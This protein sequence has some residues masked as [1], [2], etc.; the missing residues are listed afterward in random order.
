MTSIGEKERATQKRAIGLFVG[1]GYTY[2]GNWEERDGNRNIEESMLRSFL[3]KQGCREDL[4]SRAVF[5]FQKKA[6]DQSRSLYDVNRDVYNILRYGLKIKT[7]AGTNTETVWLID[8][9]NPEKND[10]AIAE[11]VTVAGRDPHAHE[12]RPD[13]VIYVNGIAVAVIELKRSSVSVAEGIRQNLTN[14]RKEFIQHFFSTTQLL[15]AG[16]DTEGLRY[17]LIETKEKY[18]LTWKE[19]GAHENPLEKSILQMFAKPR[20]LELMHNFIAYDAGIKKTARPHQYFGIKAAQA[21]LRRREGGILWHTQGSGKSL[22]MVWLAKW[23]RE[24]IRDARVV[25]ITDRKELDEQIERVFK[26][27]NEDIYRTKS[28]ADLIS[29]LNNTAPWLLCS[30]I[31]K[32][33]RKEEGEIDDYVEDVRKSLPP[34]FKAKGDIYVFVDE[35]HRTQSGDLHRAMKEI[36]PSA[37]FIGFTGTP[38]LKRDKKTSIEAFGRYIHTYKFDEAVKDGVVVDLVYE[39]RN[40]DQDITSPKKIDD[41]FEAKT[42]GLTPL[43]RAQLKQKWGTMQKVL[44][45]KSRLEK[46]AADIL[47]DM[48]QKDRLK[49]GRGNALLVTASIY[50]ACKYYEL[51]SKTDLNGK[52]GI[53][54]SYQPSAQDLKNEDSGEGDTEKI[55]QYAIY[56]NMLAEYFKLPPDEAVKKA[57]DYEKAVK[58]K[59]IEE[60][61]QMKLLVVVDKLLTGFDAPSA[62]Y[63]YIDKEMR[64]HGLFQ[65][66]CR[67]NRLDGEDKTYGYIVDYKDLF[68][69]LENSIHDYTSGALDGYEKEDVQGLMVDRLEKGRHRLE[70][71]LEKVRALCEP[72]KPP[73]GKEQYIRYFCGDTSDPAALKETEPQRLGLYTLVASL[74]RAFA[75]VADEGEAAG[76]KASVFESIRDEVKF[77]TNLR[78]DIKIASGDFIDLKQ[79]EPAMRHLID[80]YIGAKE[81]EVIASLKDTSLVDLIVARGKDFKK[82]LPQGLQE[83]EEAVAETIENNVRKLIT[84]EQPINPKYYDRMSDLLDALIKE[85][86]KKAISYEEFLTKIIELARNVKSPSKTDYPGLIDTAALRSLY[87]NLGRSEELAVRIDTA[88]R[89]VV[90]DDWRENKMK[91]KMVRNAI[92]DILVHDSETDRILEIV[93]SQNDY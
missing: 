7:E 57:E 87:D 11:E 28:G 73:R 84:D 70:E 69:S 17:G 40:I 5:E 9:E 50:Q 74:I 4:I 1:L 10:F 36:L 13:L 8:W 60:P 65:A 77:Y 33:G 12:K 92:K 45:S 44:S 6:G 3:V 26:G 30:L 81:S 86:K 49:S 47:L 82:A 16:N 91:T 53:V 42:R 37:V 68:K 24:N 71:A 56:K 21:Y 85:R 79:Y 22:T 20:L 54:T 32:F 46:I 18:Y 29:K 75:E 27:V 64:D 35:C 2:L 48:E 51:F 41:W 19:A 76:F 39:A 23:I 31:H 88:I 52:C 89:H 14:Q 38:L 62:T 25:I 67:V 55:D 78:D 43:A 34:D 80:N 72:V 90:Q 66:I 59:F 83:S 58:K 15:C 61:G 93:K 63:L